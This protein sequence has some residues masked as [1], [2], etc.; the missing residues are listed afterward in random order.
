MADVIA[1][2]DVGGLFVIVDELPFESRGD[3]AFSGSGEAG[4]PEG[5]SA[6]VE[7]AFAVRAG[8]VAVVPGYVGCHRGKFYRIGG[9]GDSQM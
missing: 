5:D 6:L 9:E 3:G 8:D 7:V 4:E 2:E 1:V